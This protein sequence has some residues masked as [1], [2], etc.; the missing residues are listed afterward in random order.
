MRTDCELAEKGVRSEWEVAEKW[1]RS[2][3]EVDEKWLKSEWE[4]VE[5]WMRSGWEV[6]EKWLRS[7]WEVAEKLR[8]WL[9]SHNALQFYECFYHF[10]SEI[11]LMFN[12][13]FTFRKTLQWIFIWRPFYDVLCFHIFSVKKLAYI[14]L[15]IWHKFVHVL[16]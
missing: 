7:G 8:S 15:L 10:S 3:W 5:K 4:V 11:N 9:T 12:Y 6:A 13:P 2:G 1:M 14:K 16:S